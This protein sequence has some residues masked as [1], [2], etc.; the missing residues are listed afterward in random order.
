MSEELNIQDLYNEYTAASQVQEATSR[1]TVPGGTYRFIGQKA[2]LRFANERSPWPGRRIVT[3][4]ANLERDGQKK[5]TIFA[6][7]SVEKDETAF[8]TPGGKLD[9]P[10]RLWG[11]VV[12]A[13]EQ[14][15]KAPVL[16]KGE[17]V[18]M[19]TKYPL[20]ATVQE[21]FTIGED[22]NGSRLYK[23]PKD[24]AE[25]KSFFEQGFTAFN[26]VTSLRKVK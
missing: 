13:F 16:S 3:I 21:T 5:G 4:Q 2:D 20:E 15:A 25:R 24:E 14:D 23:S 7:L 11:H 19:V 18:A 1:P 26:K 8:R 12:A 22:G 6:D 17:I 9:T 10:A